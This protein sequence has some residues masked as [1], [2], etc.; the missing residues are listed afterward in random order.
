MSNSEDMLALT[1][2]LD[3]LVRSADDPGATLVELLRQYGDQR[4]AEEA[5]IV[6]ASWR[7]R[8]DLVEE[9]LRSLLERE[10]R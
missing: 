2:R 3:D 8:I 4:V 7:S 9:V 5:A 1:R 10:A 6:F